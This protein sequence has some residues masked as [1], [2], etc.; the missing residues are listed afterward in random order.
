[1][2][3]YVPGMIFQWQF[4]R[5]DE[6]QFLYVS[7]GAQSV[8]GL[9]PDTLMN[10]GALLRKLAHEDDREAVATAMRRSRD[11]LRPWH[12]EHRVMRPDGNL[13]WVEGDA[14]PRRLEDGST[15]WNGYVADVT[16]SKHA[17]EELRISESKLRSLY[18]L[19]PLGIALNDM[20]GRFLQTNRAVEMI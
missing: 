16:S 12:I 3:E 8:Y 7:P 11:T 19:S 17:Q 9:R 18:D 14:V 13:G 10:D 4:S 15:V 20:D 1:I 2:A 5:E 6:G